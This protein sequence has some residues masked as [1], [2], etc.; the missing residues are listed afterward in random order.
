MGYLTKIHFDGM[1]QFQS[2]FENFPEV[3]QNARSINGSFYCLEGK[4]QKNFT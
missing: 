1:E 3:L 4:I 2:I